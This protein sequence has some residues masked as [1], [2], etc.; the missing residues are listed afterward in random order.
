MRL[1]KAMGG[2]T[3]AAPSTRDDVMD[4]VVW[5]GLMQAGLFMLAYLIKGVFLFDAP[6]HHCHEP[7]RRVRLEGHGV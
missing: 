5:I 2:G 6:N 1:S 7:P 4:W 3:L